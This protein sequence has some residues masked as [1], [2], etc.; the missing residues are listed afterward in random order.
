MKNRS[1]VILILTLF[2]LSVLVF[3]QLDLPPPPPTPSMGGSDDDSS[4]N[5]IPDQ[6]ETNNQDDEIPVDNQDS[7]SVTLNQGSSEPEDEEP[8][9]SFSFNPLE[10]FSF[11]LGSDYSMYIMV[12]SF[13][14]NLILFTILL[15]MVFS[16][17]KNLTNKIESM[18]LQLDELRDKPVAQ[19]KVK[20]EPKEEKE[21]D[22]KEEESEPKK[23]K[24]EPQSTL[25]KYLA[26]NLDKGVKYEEIEKKLVETGW[27]LDKVKEEYSKISK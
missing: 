18:K 23:E 19:P 9:S 6:N 1:V 20:V 22:K 7:N 16:T 5:I 25:G 15:V 14:L 2:L 17:R 3:A 27:P 13:A 12:G 26:E 21:P 8:Q 11:D 10:N 24:E 4:D